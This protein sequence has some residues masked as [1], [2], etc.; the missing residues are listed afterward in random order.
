MSAGNDEI[1]MIH[2]A[3]EDAA[4]RIEETQ[5]RVKELKEQTEEEVKRILKEAE[6][7]AQQAAVILKSNIDEKKAEIEQRVNSETEAYMS[8]IQESGRSRRTA[9]IQT[10]VKMLLGEES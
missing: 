3:E 6:E 2:Q 8:R 4:K 7:Q 1:E 9:A 5:R 10:V